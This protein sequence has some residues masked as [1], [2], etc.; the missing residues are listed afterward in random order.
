MAC[1][2]TI[3][4]F[5]TTRQG[6]Y[7]QAPYDSFNLADHLNDDPNNVEKNRSLL[8]TVLPNSPVWIHQV[9]GT[10]AID[11]ATTDHQPRPDADATYTSTPNT[12]CAVITADC[13]PVLLCHPEGKQ[14]AAI[15]AGWKG[16][17][18]QIIPKVCEQL[19]DQGMNWFAWLGPGIGPSAF[20]VKQDVLD[21]FPNDQ[22]AFTQ[23]DEEHWLGDLYQIAYRQ[24]E[25]CGITAIYGG[26]HCTYRESDLFFS[27]RRDGME[28]GRM[29]SLI[30]ITP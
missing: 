8:Q 29:A 21:A 25:A 2:K 10:T 30:W 9:H 4:A 23:H 20:F 26:T 3:H 7:S 11:P 15:H 27:Y 14:V 19:I 22:T 28:T 16:L 18:D 24:L 5:S 6:G 17:S 12:V 1:T 13:L